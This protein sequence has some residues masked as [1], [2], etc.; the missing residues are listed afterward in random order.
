MS[1]NFSSWVLSII[2]VVLISVIVDMV[3][4]NGKTNKLIKSI[5]AIFIVFVIVSPIVTFKNTNYFDNI[6]NSNNIQ[7]D[8]EYI[9]NI[10]KQKVSEYEKN[11]ITALDNNGYHKVDVS[12]EAEIDKEIKIK[13]V[14]V[15]ICNLV[16]SENLEHI[17]KYT[18]IIAIINSIIDV[19]REDIVFNE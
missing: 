18:N 16:L 3:L 4:P 14:Y 10:N 1:S 7:I 5:F 19:S 6:F 9:K 12:I 2:G 17:D 8:V 15:N 13:K 11:I